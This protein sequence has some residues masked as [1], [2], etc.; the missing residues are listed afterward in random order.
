MGPQQYLLLV[1]PALHCS[2][3]PCT[4][5]AVPFCGIR[6]CLWCASD[7]QQPQ[8]RSP[9][10]SLQHNP[11]FMSLSLDPASAWPSF[12]HYFLQ[13]ERPLVL[14]EEHL[15]QVIN[16]GGSAI[17]AERESGTSKMCCPVS[18]LKYQRWRCC[19]PAVLEGAVEQAVIWASLITLSSFFTFNYSRMSGG[20]REH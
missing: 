17:P 15:I 4:A 8:T 2:V 12:Q 16:D 14:R 9:E 20:E 13:S 11:A 10:A 1:C 18:T 6:W 3:L 7:T 5:R 19:H